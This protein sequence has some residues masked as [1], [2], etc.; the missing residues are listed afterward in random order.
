MLLVS[1]VY[2]IDIDSS[3][4]WKVYHDNWMIK[5]TIWMKTSPYLKYKLY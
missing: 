2:E 1:D 3:F 4:A 5:I